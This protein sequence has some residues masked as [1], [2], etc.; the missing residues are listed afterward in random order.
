MLENLTSRAKR[1]QRGVNSLRGA[2]SPRRSHPS[3]HH[4][5]RERELSLAELQTDL[6]RLEGGFNNRLLEAFSDLTESGDLTIRRAA[7]T[8][9]LALASAAMDIATSPNPKLALLDMSAFFELT[10]AAFDRYW[11]PNYFA[12]SGPGLS[13]ALRLSKA[14]AWALVNRA[15]HAPQAERLR[16]FLN[17]WVSSHGQIR[18]AEL[19][20]FSQF[21]EALEKI[22]SVDSREGAISGMI[23]QINQAFTSA[24]A[25]RLLGERA[26]YYS[27]RMPF[28]LRLQARAAVLD[29]AQE[30]SAIAKGPVTNGILIAAT[31]SAGYIAAKVIS[32]IVL[33]RSR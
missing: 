5:E 19:L 31:M 20:R 14:E 6:L 12:Q 3:A 28:L 32:A 1:I 17:D 29:M 11:I 10:E 26:L 30:A 13:T 2:P 22:K 24:D 7:L 9:H 4:R 15:F 21:S 8:R 16:G 33:R 27:Q 23:R 18:N 25:A